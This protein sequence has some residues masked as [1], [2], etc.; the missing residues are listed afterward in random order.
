MT[1]LEES[2]CFM[3]WLLELRE[4]S[5]GCMSV[6]GTYD[7]HPEYCKKETQDYQ[8]WEQE[9]RSEGPAGERAYALCRRAAESAWKEKHGDHWTSSKII[10]NRVLGLPSCGRKSDTSQAERR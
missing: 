5:L 6:N 3:D 8:E 2:V 4:I 1:T 7:H 9:L 10:T